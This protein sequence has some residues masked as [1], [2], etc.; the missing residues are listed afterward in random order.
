M[1]SNNFNDLLIDSYNVFEP[2]LNEPDEYYFA[3]YYIAQD[4]SMIPYWSYPSW[5]SH[6]DHILIT[7]EIFNTEYDAITV[8]IDEI[9]FNSFNNY[10]N[11]ISDHRPVGIRISN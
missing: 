4:P 5:P 6:I 2:F 11:L 10:D 7:N 1:S 9:F 8:R 3:D